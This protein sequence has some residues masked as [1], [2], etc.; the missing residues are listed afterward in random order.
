MLTMLSAPPSNCGLS[1][2][3]MSLGNDT[4]ICNGSFIMLGTGIGGTN[5]QWSTGQTANVILVN[6]PG[7]YWLSVSNAG[8]TQTDTINI[9]FSNCNFPTTSFSASALSLC[10]E[11][12]LDFTDQ[13][14]NNPTSW[15][16]TFPGGF[17]SSSTLQNPHHICY[18]VPGVYPVTLISSNASGSDTLTMDSLITVYLVPPQPTIIIHNDTL[19]SSTGVSYQWY[20]NNV[21]I[22]GATDSFYVATQQGAYSVEIYDASGCHNTSAD[23]IMGLDEADFASSILLYPNPSNGELTISGLPPFVEHIEIYDAIGK[24]TYAGKVLEN[25]SKINTTTFNEGI[26]WIRIYGNSKS[27]VKRFTVLH[28]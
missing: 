14:S 17:P 12:C 4:M 15:E 18:N 11:N 6:S 19:I 10:T 1:T 21:L 7:T 13:S 5:Y 2:T 22:N 23:I 28:N 20:F 9:N 24:L 8:C 27:A 16:W 25:T 26:Y 3:P